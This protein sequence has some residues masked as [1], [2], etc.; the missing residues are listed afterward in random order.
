MKKRIMG[1]LLVTL[2]LVLTGL[3]SYGTAVHAAPANTNTL[4]ALPAPVPC[5]NCWHPAL[6]TS[7]QWQLQGNIDQSYNVRMYDVDMFDTPASVV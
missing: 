4:V 6:N 7:W 1:S 2:L 3:A 5:P